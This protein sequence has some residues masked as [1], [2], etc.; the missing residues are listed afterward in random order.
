MTYRRFVGLGTALTLAVFCSAMGAAPAGA[1]D[2]SYAQSF[3]CVG[4]ACAVSPEHEEA[5]PFKGYAYLTLTN[6]GTEPWGDFHLEIFQVTGETVENVDFIVSTPYEPT[7]SQSGLTW[8]VDNSLPSGATL[9][10][11]FYGDP[12][13]PTETATFTVYTDN[14]TDE[15]SFFGTMLYPTPVPEPTTALLVAAG[16]IGFA[17]NGRRRSA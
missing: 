16:L 10:L 2:F 15:V 14:T 5:D 13:L 6:T 7:S 1:H 17:V 8:S 3:G 11:Y 12:V 4:I 9:D